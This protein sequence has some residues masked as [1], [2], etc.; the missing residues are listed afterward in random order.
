MI[1]PIPECPRRAELLP[2]VRAQ[3]LQEANGGCEL[4]DR[5]DGLGAARF[6]N[7]D[8]EPIY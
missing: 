1:Q 6:I 2:E 3:I 7:T 5:T 8:T 4:Q